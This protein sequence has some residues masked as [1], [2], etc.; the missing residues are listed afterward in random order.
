[1]K[2][3]VEGDDGNA[4][5]AAF[6]QQR[7][8]PLFKEGQFTA[9]GVGGIVNASGPVT[10]AVEPDAV[11]DDLW[12]A[13]QM[14]G[15]DDLQPWIEPVHLAEMS[16]K[17]IEDEEIPRCGGPDGDEFAQNGFG[18]GEGVVFEQRTFGEH[19]PDE[20]DVVVGEAWRRRCGGGVAEFAT[21]IEMDAAAPM[22]AGLFGV[23]PQR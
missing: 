11:K 9:D 13:T 8:G 1:M 18:D 12:R 6:V 19:A 5:V 20:G 4:P 17:A 21:E 14:D 23:V 3:D 7:C 2:R 15:A 10:A 16:R 22:K